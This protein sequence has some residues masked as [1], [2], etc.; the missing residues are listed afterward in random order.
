VTVPADAELDEI[1]LEELKLLRLDEDELELDEVLLEE[2]ELLRLEE[3][4][5]SELLLLELELLR[6][7]EDELELAA[8]KSKT[9]IPVIIVII[10]PL[11]VT[12]SLRTPVVVSVICPDPN[13]ISLF[14]TTADKISPPA[15]AHEEVV[16]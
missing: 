16:G 3:L 2:L 1:L 12:E 6:L 15:V 4:E 7:D 13:R 5:L 14:A 8:P 11:K 10:V 9:R